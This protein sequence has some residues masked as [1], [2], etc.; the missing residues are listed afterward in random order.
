MFKNSEAISVP[1][2]IIAKIESQADY[3][4]D[5]DELGDGDHGVNMSK[6]MHLAQKGN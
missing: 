6:G 2:N 1:L 5:L 3:L 4:G